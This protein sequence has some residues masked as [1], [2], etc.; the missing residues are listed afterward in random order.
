MYARPFHGRHLAAPYN[1]CLYYLYFFLLKPYA[2]RGW[3]QIFSPVAFPPA[4]PVM[5]KVVAIA[6]RLPSYSHGKSC[7]AFLGVK[8]T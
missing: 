3:K 6:A 5:A 1:I 4:D 8:Y 7:G 2:G